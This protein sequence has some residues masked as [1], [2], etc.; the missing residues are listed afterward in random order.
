[1]TDPTRTYEVGA[2]LADPASVETAIRSR[3]SV[4]AFLDRPVPREILE[5]L[6]GLASQ[7]PSGVNTQPWRVYVLQGERR[8]EHI[9]VPSHRL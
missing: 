8:A 3:A 5:E 4:R 9:K 2:R 6:L 1:M 7:A